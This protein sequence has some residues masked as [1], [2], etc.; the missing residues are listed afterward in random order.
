MTRLALAPSG[1]KRKRNAWQFREF[2]TMT[3]VTRISS[4]WVIT[5]HNCSYS[6]LARISTHWVAWQNS[7]LICSDDT[8]NL[9]NVVDTY[10]RLIFMI[11]RSRKRFTPPLHKGEQICAHRVYDAALPARFCYVSDGDHSQVTQTRANMSLW[12]FEPW[13]SGSLMCS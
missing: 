10:S 6:S 7:W 2:L 9:S 13:G 11:V 4:H 8:V 12:L 5:C 1:C 3:A